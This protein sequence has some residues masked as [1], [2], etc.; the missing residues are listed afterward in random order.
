MNGAW[1]PRFACST[2]RDEAGIL[3]FLSA[4]RV[5]TIAP[6]AQQYRLVR[7]HEGY[8][9]PTPEFYRRLPDTTQ[10]VRRGRETRQHVLRELGSIPPAPIHDRLRRP[11]APA[12]A[13]DA[14]SGPAPLGELVPRRS[15]DRLLQHRASPADPRIHENILSHDNL[16]SAVE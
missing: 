10:A 11:A 12:H 4:D 15:E 16:N 14:E 13:L 5:A 2:P 6:F 7:Q 9:R 8:R 3:R 1:L